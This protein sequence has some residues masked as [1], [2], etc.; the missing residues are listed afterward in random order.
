MQ[1]SQE[2]GQDLNES[3]E[4]NN[5]DQNDNQDSTQVDFIDGDEVMRSHFTVNE[6]KEYPGTG[7]DDELSEDDKTGVITFKLTN[8]NATSSN[9]GDSVQEGQ[10]QGHGADHD[11]E[12]EREEWIGMAVDRFANTI[13][14]MSITLITAVLRAGGGG[15]RNQNYRY[16]DRETG[17][18]RSGGD[19]YHFYNRENRDDRRDRWDSGREKGGNHRK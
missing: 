13:Q 18:Q 12:R 7:N 10:G 3:M 2:F 19:R 17:E 1:S 11:R 9:V 5:D 14:T 8:N 4:E 15:S 16:Y 6:M